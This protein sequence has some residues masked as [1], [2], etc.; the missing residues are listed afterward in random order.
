MSRTEERLKIYNTKRK[1]EEG[2]VAKEEQTEEK[3]KDYL[4]A[5]QWRNG[6]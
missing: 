2:R 3:K 6:E 4:K 5:G 1:M